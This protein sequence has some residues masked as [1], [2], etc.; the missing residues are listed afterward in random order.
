MTA[1]SMIE[2]LQNSGTQELLLQLGKKSLELTINIFME[3]GLVGIIAFFG[4]IF[5]IKKLLE[6]FVGSMPSKVA[7]AVAV[8]LA[9]ATA[10]I[11]ILFVFNFLDG[12]LGGLL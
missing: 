10:G 1:E 9:I 5:I 4:T 7:W 8:V 2:V 12:I 11:T 6:M 3:G